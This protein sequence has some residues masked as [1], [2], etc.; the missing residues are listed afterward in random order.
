MFGLRKRQAEDWASPHERARARAVQRM[1]GPLG[2]TEAAWLDGHLAECKACRRRAAEYQENRDLLRTLREVNPSPPRDLWARTAAAIE[3][4]SRRG[5]RGP[6][7]GVPIGA[8]SGVLVIAVVLG[9]TLLSNTPTPVIAPEANAPASF[10][11]AAATASLAPGPVGTPLAV[12]A[13][14][15]RAVWGDADGNLAVRNL[16][17]ES[18]C[19]KKSDA[20]CPT[21]EDRSATD[22]ALTARPQTIISSPD[23]KQAVIVSKPDE[24]NANEVIVFTLPTESTPVETPEPSPEPPGTPEVSEPPST[25]SAAPETPA[26]SAEPSDS[27]V[28]SGTPTESVEPSSEPASPTPLETDPPDATPTP[29]AIAIASGLIVVGQTEAY[30]ADGKWFAFTAR[31][32][33]SDLGPDIYLWRV[34]TQEAAPVTRDH[35][36]VFA[37]WDGERIVGSRPSADGPAVEGV[38]FMID[39]RTGEETELGVGWRPIVAPDGS[40]ALVFDGSVAATDGGRHIAP[41]EGTLELRDWDPDT[42]TAS[43][44]G[45]AVIDVAGSMFDARWAE[46]GI[47]FAVWVQDVAD[48]SFGRLSLYFVDPDTGELDQPENAPRE[49]PAL[50]GFSI[51]QGRLAWAT[52]SGQGGEGSRVQ[53]VAWTKDG[54][55]SAETAP[56]DQVVVIR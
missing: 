3:V 40:Q 54:V 49:E 43:S 38:I 11:P 34:G 39:P 24:S 4:E 26:T 27:P 52:P 20:D 2:A 18:V 17:V 44:R 12:A 7:R 42:G 21:V 19:S 23:H 53:I 8:L 41:A 5:R 48:P 35:R 10:P 46:N 15:V 14:D 37:S 51:G 22:V 32:A 56:G 55:G 6:V 16:R 1:D 13:G 33:D 47:A 25:E 9:A 29:E 50:P 31:P 45:D 30:S 28:P 36:S